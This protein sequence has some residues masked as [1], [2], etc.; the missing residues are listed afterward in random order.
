MS[1]LQRLHPERAA[2]V[3]PA[4]DPLAA[5]L[6]AERSLAGLG[7]FRICLG[8]VV[9]LRWLP[10]C[11]HARELYAS[12]AFV[13]P[14][15]WFERLG[16]PHP[17]GPL[18]VLLCGLLVAALTAVTVGWQTRAAA[19]LAAGLLMYFVP[20]NEVFICAVDQLAIL[21]LFLIALS[22]AGRILA[23]DAVRERPANKSRSAWPRGPVW[24]QRLLALTFA[25][26]Y[27]F[28]PMYRLGCHGWEY[29]DGEIL[30]FGLQRWQFATAA[31]HWIAGSPVLRAGLA[32]MVIFGEWFMAAGLFVRRVRPVAMVLGIGMHLGILFT[33]LIPPSLALAMIAS[34]VLFIEPETLERWLDRCVCRLRRARK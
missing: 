25:S 8:A 9:L 33:L 31:S 12:D 6:F 4:A 3:R 17:P 2:Q 14:W 22:P 16:A 29:L 28:A 24:T 26:V 23:F 18:A 19:G 30:G 11:L 7:V 20:A 10:R 5:W 34:Y 21:A 1:I 15:G 27:A 32:W 13:V